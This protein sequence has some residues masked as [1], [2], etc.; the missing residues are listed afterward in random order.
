MASMILVCTGNICRSPMAEGFLRSALA[1][2]FGERAPVL[3]SAGTI[4]RDGEPA[5]AEAAQAA[6]ERGIDISGHA[7]SALTSEMV[8]GADLVIGMAGEHCDAAI[9]FV[10]NAGGRTFT[11]KE[12]V[13]LIE[14]LPASEHAEP[15][16]LAVRVAE[17]DA[18][19][20]SGFAGNTLDEDV[21]DPLGLPLDT[22]RAVAWELDE[23]CGRLVNGLFGKLP[24]AKGVFD[25]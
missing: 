12:L 4:G 21:V 22:Y 1:R 24:A 19:R 15:Q 10:P 6:D 16:S 11:L 5:T 18:L 14:R 8:A 17:A 2:R 20:R 9:G 7:A 25:D 13:R 23:W 3:W